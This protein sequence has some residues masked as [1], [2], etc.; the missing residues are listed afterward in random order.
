MRPLARTLRTA[1]ALAALLAFAAPAFAQAAVRVGFVFS[2]GNVPGTLRAYKALLDERPDLRGQVSLTFLT[3]S[4][5]DD[6]SPQE[7]SESNVLL[8]DVMNQQMLDRFNDKHRVDLIAAVR[9]KGTVL[10]IGEGVLPRQRYADQG[11]VFDD[12]ARAFWAHLG[13]A[14]QLGLLKLAIAR[15]G[16]KGLTIPK[17]E[18]SLA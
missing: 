5:F 10:A 6:A 11:V 7:L 3:E 13:F 8:L 9:R 2:D 12:T 18:P 16:V 4:T 17:P 1:L 14:N 15:A